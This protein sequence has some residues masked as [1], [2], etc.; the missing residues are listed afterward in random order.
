MILCKY[1]FA[2]LY[3]Q[4]SSPVLYKSFLD[5]C[6]TLFRGDNYDKLYENLSL[7]I[8]E[9]LIDLKIFST[10]SEKTQKIKEIEGIC[11]AARR[12]DLR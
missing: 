11:S 12:I 10:C 9:I 2:E 7:N 4:I 8:A 1:S 3:T 6:K 5:I